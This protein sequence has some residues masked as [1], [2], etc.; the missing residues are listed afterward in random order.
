MKKSR[1]IL[2]ELNS[3]STDRNKHHV[4]E[5]RVE[6]LVSSASNIKEILYSLYE[7]DVALDLERRLINSIKS[8]DP[9]KFS[10]GINKANK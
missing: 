8:G 10:R 3:I 7:E 2:E 1:S 9:K 5:N 4:L 6:H